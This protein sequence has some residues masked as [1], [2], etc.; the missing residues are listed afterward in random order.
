MIDEFLSHVYRQAPLQEKS[1]TLFFA[2]TPQ[3][4]EDFA[5]FLHQYETLWNQPDIGGLEGLAASYTG[6]IR[7]YM[8]C[9]MD[10]IRSGTYSMDSQHAALNEI[11]SQPD[12]M[13]S[14][15]LGLAVSDFLW[16]SHYRLLQF[17]KSCADA[18]PA[19][20]RFLEIGSGAGLFL[21]HLLQSV[22]DGATID[23]V[24]ISSASIELSQ[25]LLAVSNPRRMRQVRFIQSDIADYAPGTPYD[26]II[27]G[28][29]LEHIDDPASVL[30]VLKNHLAPGGALYL[31]TCANCPAPDHVYLFNT[32]DEIRDLI[33][34]SGF[35]IDR[36][37]VIPSL[38][39]KSMEY[40]IRHKLDIS[41]GVLL[42]KP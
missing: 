21:N 10:F 5:R 17:F 42:R 40:H 7:Q 30:K 26:F 19:S 35:A 8:M 24:D 11:Y 23:V 25:K 39:A 4:R 32:V 14:Y 29:V 12:K 15:M 20:G 31:T 34:N 37:T 38:E 6:M 36:E 28:E 16:F 18:Q 2:H 27:M 13:L 41:Y 3:A 33:L 22:S 9:R 1:L